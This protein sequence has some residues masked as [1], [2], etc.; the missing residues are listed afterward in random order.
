M[1]ILVA[2]KCGKKLRVKDELAGKRVKCPGCAQVVAVPAV[3]EPPEL[4]EVE[5]VEERVAVPPAA[6]R[7]KPTARPEPQDEGEEGPRRSRGSDSPTPYWVRSNDLLALS[8]DAVY[9][10]TLDD[11]KMR[12]AQAA[13]AEGRPAGEV[14]D[15]ADTVIPLDIITK[16]EGNL[17]HTFF[18]I[19]YKEPDAKEESEKTIHCEDQESRDEIVKALRQRL[20]PDWERKVKEY[21]RLRASLEP[22]IV[23]GLFGFLTF[24]FYMAGTHPE[25]DSGGKTVRTNWIGAIFVWVY[26]LLGPWGVVCLGGLVI[27]LG[28]AWLV[29]R[30]I[31]PPLML[32]LTPREAPRRRKRRSDREED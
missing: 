27:A 32:T 17:Y 6:R 22:L 29:A 10:T 14:L 11:K 18:D 15:G 9:L 24:C 19:K 31:K 7:P 21:T 28:I 25:S 16:V 30:M 2:C 26:N 1:P 12:K 4:E 3:G 13:L 20:G 8:D 23:I 5:P